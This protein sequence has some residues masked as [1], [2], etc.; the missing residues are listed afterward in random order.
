[1]Q[2]L[3]DNNTQANKTRL[4][5]LDKICSNVRSVKQH[6]PVIS[7][8]TQT[9]RYALN[10]SASSLILLDEENKALLNK[11]ADGPLGK[12]FRR[13]PLNK[14]LGITR[15]VIRNGKPLMVKDISAD[16]RF[17][18]SKDEVAG[19]VPRSVVCVPL[20]IK[21]EVIGA[22]EVL[23]KLDGN[24]F[25]EHDAQILAGLAN[26]AALT[27]ENIRLNEDLLYSYKDT[28]QKL[29][30]LLDV[31]ESTASKHS[32]RVAEHARITAK[33][34]SLSAEEKQSI[35]YAAILLDIGM[36]SI[37]KSVLN[38]REKLTDEEWNLIRKH[39]VIGYNLLR[40]IP[41]LNQVSKLILYHHERFD[42]KGYPC[43][44]KGDTIPIGARVIAV[45]D[46]FDS[47]TV[48]HSYR[49]AMSAK[50]ALEE[51]GRCSGSQ[52]CPVAAR[53]F[54]VGYIKSNASRRV[55]ITKKSLA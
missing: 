17:H 25:N 20:G 16:E 47:M 19:V 48:K 8:I 27:I 28:V 35:E 11:Y 23:N 34:L 45:A 43:G 31:R 53:A 33:A 12:Q 5:L 7:C 46:A 36:L 37:P 6:L 51:I 30:S 21:G 42:G 55:K 22:I 14:Q 50:D 15:W 52:F 32:K 18:N 41:S 24:N 38:K 4:D 54:F 40:G 13:F 3:K 26:N 49:A 1:V 29:V 10:A 44:L 2:N 9:T 39:P